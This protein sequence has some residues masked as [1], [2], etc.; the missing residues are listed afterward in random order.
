MPSVSD[1]VMLDGKLFQMHGAA[2]KKAWSPILERH[3]NSV[4]RADVDADHSHLLA[5]L[6]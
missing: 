6:S 5:S 3:D 1:A 4:T 2:M